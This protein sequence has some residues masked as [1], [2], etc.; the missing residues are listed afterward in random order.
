MEK[1]LTPPS[2]DN[3]YMFV[4]GM[5]GVN[6]VVRFPH[7]TS[8]KNVIINKAELVLYAATL[9]SDDA[10]AFYPASSVVLYYRDSDGA[11]QVINDVLYSTDDLS[12]QFGGTYRPG[13]DTAPGYYRMNLSAHIQDMVEGK[14]SNELLVTLL[15]K[16]ENGSRAVL[17]GASHPTYKAKLKIAYTQ[18]K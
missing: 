17:N 12:A 16:T 15:P 14:V 7:I 13:T 10:A 2:I 9:P 18:L 6:G 11:I 8:L 3:P 5:A 4:Q 1:Y